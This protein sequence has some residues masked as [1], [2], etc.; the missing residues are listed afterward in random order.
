MVIGEHG[1]SSVPIWSGVCIGGTSLS[2]VDPK[3]GRTDDP[4]NFMELHQK[5]IKR[6]FMFFL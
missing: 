4:E 6:L 2:S 1:D 3:I 5:I